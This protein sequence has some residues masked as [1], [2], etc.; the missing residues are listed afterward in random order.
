MKTN[1]WKTELKNNGMEDI[2]TLH[3]V[4]AGANFR[5]F[6]LLLGWSN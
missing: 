2:N 3:Y 4:Q 1:W 5:M 6:W